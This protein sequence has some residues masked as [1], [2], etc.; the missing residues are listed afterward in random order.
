M[1][2]YQTLDLHF[3]IVVQYIKHMSRT[4]IDIHWSTKCVLIH[5]GKLSNTNLLRKY[6]N[7]L[8]IWDRMNV[9]SRTNGVWAENGQKERNTHF[10]AGVDKSH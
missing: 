4:V 5:I 8:Y 6:R 9:V 3:F 1:S 2:L 10:L 7:K